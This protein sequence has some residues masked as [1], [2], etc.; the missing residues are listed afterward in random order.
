M[1]GP[2]F[3]QVSAIDRI[4]PFGRDALPVIERRIARASRNADGAGDALPK[5]Q[6]QRF[7]WEA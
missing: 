5:V 4:H 1:L 3:E 6:R 2:A 7:E